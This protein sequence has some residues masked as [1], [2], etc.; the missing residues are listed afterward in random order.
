MNK[1]I[2]CLFCLLLTGFMI[3][4]VPGFG[5]ET[6]PSTVATYNPESSAAPMED[7]ASGKMDVFFDVTPRQ[8]ASKLYFDIR[9]NLPDGMVFMSAI[10]DEMG[11]THKIT[12]TMARIRA[13]I[14][15]GRLT[16]GPFPLED[17]PF[18]PGEYK[19]YINSYP[20]EYQPENVI[21]IIGKNGGNL[22]GRYIIGGMVLFGKTFMITG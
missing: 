10:R 14:S 2:S 7:A 15:G 12:R 8:E 3:G 21:E 20:D 18:P 9:T 1:L 6:V 13:E 19:L 17:K 4:A 11:I 16:L 5:E 22:T